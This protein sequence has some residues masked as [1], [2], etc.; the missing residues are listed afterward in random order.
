MDVP[1]AQ[2]NMQ[3]HQRREAYGGDDGGRVHTASIDTHIPH[4]NEQRTSTNAIPLGAH[5]K[6]RARHHQSGD[7]LFNDLNSAHHQSREVD[8]SRGRRGEVHRYR[9][10]HSIENPAHVRSRSRSRADNGSIT[11]RPSNTGEPDRRPSPNMDDGAHGHLINRAGRCRSRSPSLRRNG[12]QNVPSPPG[13]LGNG[14]VNRVLDGET[15]YGVSAARHRERRSPSPWDSSA[16]DAIPT[17]PRIPEDPTVL[18]GSPRREISTS[19]RHRNHQRLATPPT[20]KRRGSRWGTSEQESDGRRLDRG[21]HQYSESMDDNRRLSITSQRRSSVGEPATVRVL[22]PRIENTIPAVTATATVAPTVA[23]TVAESI[24]DFTERAVIAVAL[25]D[26]VQDSDSSFQPTV[27]DMSTFKDKTGRSHSSGSHAGVQGGTDQVE[28]LQANIESKNDQ[29]AP[30]QTPVNEHDPLPQSKLSR[31]LGKKS[32][33]TLDRSRDLS[34]LSKSL[35]SRSTALSQESV[36]GATP[37]VSSK[38]PNVPSASSVHPAQQLDRPKGE[39]IDE[40]AAQEVEVVL[41]RRRK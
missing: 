3:I 4:Y 19:P 23:A 40:L 2:L 1:G 15:Q 37:R 27:E 29:S 21:R 25:S 38:P 28:A 10:Q 14:E 34:D 13:G 18:A 5:R 36:Y 26:K 39:Q 8:S 33:V 12:R 35:S 17:G 7:E 9:T 11:R 6:E 31:G 30:A 41:F 22:T 24:P 32:L 16:M 20:K